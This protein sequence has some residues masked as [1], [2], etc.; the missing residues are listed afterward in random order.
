MINTT[1]CYS[2]TSGSSVADYDKLRRV[3]MGNVGENGLAPATGNH[4]GCPYNRYTGAY[5]HSNDSG[6]SFAKVSDS[7]QSTKHALLNLA[8][9]QSLPL[10]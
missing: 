2:A 6:R 5:F 9:F 8:Y 10:I 4:K 3:D 1:L 7:A